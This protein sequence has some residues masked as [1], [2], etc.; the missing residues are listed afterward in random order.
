MNTGY[1]RPA[2]ATVPTVYGI[3]T[4]EDIVMVSNQTQV[5]T[6]PTVYGIETTTDIS[7]YQSI[8]DS[9]NSTYRLRY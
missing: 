9:C 5:A 1:L 4:S 6:V 7:N 8:I 3:E 2:V